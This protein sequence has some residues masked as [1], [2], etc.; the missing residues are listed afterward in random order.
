MK[1][2]ILVAAILL[3]AI[4][5]LL[6]GGTFALVGTVLMP[7]LP[8]VLVALLALLGLV[9]NWLPLTPGGLGVGEAA[10]AAIFALA[11]HTGGARMLLAWRVGMLPLAALGALF[12]VRG[13][14]RA[15]AR[16]GQPGPA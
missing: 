1:R 3:S 6:L 13:R 2:G 7:G 5:Q 11:G 9:A 15:V 4:G 12:Y 10:F 14:S 16:Q 8:H